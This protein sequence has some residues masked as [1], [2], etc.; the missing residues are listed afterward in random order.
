MVLDMGKMAC[1]DKTR[2]LC[3]DVYNGRNTNKTRYFDLS[4]KNGLSLG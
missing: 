4:E 2:I 1:F 3:H